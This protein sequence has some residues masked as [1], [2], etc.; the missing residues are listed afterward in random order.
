MA[1]DMHDTPLE[2]E[3]IHNPCDDCKSSDALTINNDG[4]TKCY[5]CDKF[6]PSNREVSKKPT[7]FRSSPKNSQ[8]LT[9][10]HQDIPVRKISKETCKKW[11]VEIVTTKDNK[12]AIAFPYYNSKGARVAQKL[13]FVDKDFMFLGDAKNPM[14]FG[15]H[16]WSKGKK[17]VIT[18]GELDAMSVSQIQNHKWP[19]V[20]LPTGAKAGKNILTAH[21]R[22][23]EDNFEEII[24]M[25]DMDV[26]GQEAALECASVFTPGK[27]GIATLP[28][29]DANECL[30]EGKVQEL[31]QAIWNPKAFR[32]DG[33]VTISDVIP[34]IDE[35]P[36]FGLSLPWKSLTDLTYGIKLPGVWVWTSGS[37]M[38]KT[39]FF[40]D[41]AA[42]L[43]TEH[44][45]KIGMIL[46]E[47]ETQDTVVDLAGKLV[48]KCFNSPDT[49][50]NKEERTDAIKQLEDS[51]C[52]YL[53]D[54]YGHDDYDAIRSVIRHMVL[55]YGCKVIFLDHITAFT[56]G[57]G[58]E[59]NALAEKMM[60]ELSS[61]A[62]ELKFNLQIIS[63][64]RKSDN[65]R[66]PA[67]EGGRVK[68]DD[69]KGS[70]AIKQWSNII[71]GLERNQQSMDEEESQTT[72]VR[73]LKARGVGKNVGQTVRVKYLPETATLVQADEAFMEDLPF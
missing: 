15:Q 56:D 40:K 70:G 33:I 60:K 47:E 24:L 58:N 64:V 14:L 41:I 9:G 22:W 55:G 54:H 62:R 59:A 63:H 37:G 39:E 61:M 1:N 72:T 43:V 48:G 31:T 16:L 6:T 66:K 68:I 19:V 45:T 67:E 26:V 42:H 49:A 4:S 34:K 38:G 10:T 21:V 5:A 46:L 44:Q 73:I 51:D 35:K 28:C 30:M 52:V 32:P 36:T 12:K 2:A 25:F 53:Y 57:M 71:I 13:R 11:G 69:L 65:S 18:E 7:E 17:I 20:S 3:S 27:C 50:Y 8:L 23:L 29:K